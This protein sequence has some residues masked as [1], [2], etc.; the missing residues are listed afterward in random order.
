M[1]APHRDLRHHAARRRAVAGLQH[2]PGGEA[3]HRAAA[4]AA[5]RRRHRGRLP[6]RLARRARMRVR[7]I[8]ERGA[9]A[10]RVAALR[11]RQG[12]RHRGRAARALRGAARPRMHVFLATSAIHLKHKLRITAGGGAGAGGRPRCGCARIAHARRR[13]LGRGRLAHRLRVPAR[14][15]A[16]GAS[17]PGA[18][19]LNVPDTVGYAVPRRVRRAHRRELA[20]DIP[21]AVISRA[22]PQRPRPGG[23]QLAGRGQGRRAA[24]GVHH[25][26]HRRARRQHLA[27]GD[28]DGAQGA[29]RRTAASRPRAHRADHADAA[30]CCRTITGVW[31]QPNKAVVGRNAFAH[32]AGIHQHGVLKNP[33]TYEIMTPASVGV[34][35]D[36]AG[37]RQAL[38]QARGRV[39]PAGARA[40]TLGRRASSKTLTARV[41]DAGRP[42]EV[43]LRRRPAGARRPARPERRARLVRYQVVSGNEV[44]PTA[45]VEV[46]VDGAAPL[47]LRGGQR[48]ARRRPQGRRR[49]ARPRASSCSSCTRA[50][51]TARQGRA[52]RGRR[53]RARRRAA[54]PPARPRARTPS[55]RR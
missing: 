55:R 6:D 16:G 14:G 17:R 11:A 49:R 8:A 19:V 9:R 32:E 12:G 3:P 13:V 51:V 42:Q 18:T 33:L 37:A 26:R 48:A 4:R 24:G 2:D 23:G 21:G 29:A 41:K 31:P 47:R 25:Q 50:R 1:T 15:A 10:R 53:A 43:R 30:T 38:R 39:A 27:R 52:G 40:S 7:A 20:R 46:E 22:L 34:A 45:T 5:G 35:R 36:A 44:L 28:G 54:S